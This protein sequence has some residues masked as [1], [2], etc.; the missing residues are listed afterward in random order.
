MVWVGNDL[1]R[2]PGPKG[3]LQPGQFSI[4]IKKKKG[5]IFYSLDSGMPCCQERP[6]MAA[7]GDILNKKTGIFVAKETPEF[8]TGK[9]V[10]KLIKNGV[11]ELH[12]SLPPSFDGTKTAGSVFILV[13]IPF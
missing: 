12:P 9:A 7:K 4:K 13:E 1:P 10:L 6:R 5:I 2:P 8:Q 3:H 11:G